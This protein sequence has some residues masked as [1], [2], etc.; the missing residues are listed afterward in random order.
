MT[1]K[2]GNLNKDL[3]KLSDEFDQFDQEVKALTMDQM[4]KAPKADVA[5]QTELSQKQIDKSPDIYLK[6]VRSIGVRDKFNEKFRQD[7]E[8]QKE[9]VHFIAEHKETPGENI[10]IWTRPFG[11]M[12]AEEWLVPVNK[13]VWGP[14]Y[15]AEQIKR[16]SYHRLKTS[17][18][19]YDSN[20]AYSFYGSPIVDTTIQRLDAQPVIRNRSVFMGANK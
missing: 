3:Q 9:Y 17:D 6:P 10:E 8:F 2:K 14:R 13:P 20:G 19:S 1:E 7:Y 12:P 5:P 15:L 18:I 16:K 4:N 11:G